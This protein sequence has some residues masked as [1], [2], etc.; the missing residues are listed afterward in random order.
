MS[1]LLEIATFSLD[2][3]LMADA[4]GADRVELCVDYAAGG[5]TPPMEMI[6]KATKGLNCP[7][8]VMIRP[9]EGNF[10]YSPSELE[11]MKEELAQAKQG[12][13]HGFVFGI[14]REDG[15]IDETAN[16]EL[17]ALA[18][19][20]PCT[21]HRAFDRLSDQSTGLETLI[22]CGFKR[23]LTSGG[24]GS[25][26][27]NLDSLKNLVAQA[28]GRIVVMPGG[29]VRPENLKYISSTVDAMEYHTA[30]IIGNQNLPDQGAIKAM[31]KA[32]GL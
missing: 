3:A 29:G 13:A 2:A 9:R 24:P 26:A 32:L 30:A 22:R 25:A 27:D 19:P 7:F 16:T 17:V 4:A 18:A 21:F 8:F 23:V 6:A 10:V 1:P 14:L 5:L 11:Q 12:G 31:K 28:A 20:L 15:T